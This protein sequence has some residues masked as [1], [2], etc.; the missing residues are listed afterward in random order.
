MHCDDAGAGLAIK[1][2]Y[3]IR[4][5]SQVAA[6]FKKTDQLLTTNLAYGF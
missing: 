1:V 4:S 3:Q 6:G 5:N 2:G